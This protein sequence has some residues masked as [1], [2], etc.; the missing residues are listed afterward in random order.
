MKSLTDAQRM[1]VFVMFAGLAIATIPV[2]SAGPQLPC[3]VAPEDI[4]SDSGCI[5]LAP[6]AGGEKPCGDGPGQKPCEAG[7]SPDPRPPPPSRCGPLL[8]DPVNVLLCD[9][10]AILP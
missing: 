4:N 7:N 6:R 2:T 9:F 1:M 8:G 10:D 3:S 5:H